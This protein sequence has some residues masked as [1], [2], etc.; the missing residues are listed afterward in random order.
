MKKSVLNLLRGG[1]FALAAV[2][3]F[4]FTQPLKVTTA[5][6]AER[7]SSGDVIDWHPVNISN[8]ENYECD[9]LVTVGCIYSQP[10]ESSTMLEE[11]E[12]KP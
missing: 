4:A 6:G 5:Y 2:A 3:A 10:S 9:E 7:D 8:P 11:G 1:V 12:F